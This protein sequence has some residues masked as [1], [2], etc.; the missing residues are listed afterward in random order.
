[1]LKRFVAFLLL[2]TTTGTVFG[3]REWLNTDSVTISRGEQEIALKVFVAHDGCLQERDSLELLVEY[4][5]TEVSIVNE[6]LETEKSVNSFLRQQLWA[7]DTEVKIKDGEIDRLN[8]DLKKSQR[9]AVFSGIG[10]GIGGAVVGALL[11]VMVGF[12]AR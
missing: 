8:S 6:T 11:G 10:Y 1:M 3:Q 7:K 9:K 2:I 4:K 12:L 5:K